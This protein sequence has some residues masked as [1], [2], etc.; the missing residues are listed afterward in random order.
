MLCHEIRGMLCKTGNRCH[1]CSLLFAV[2]EPTYKALLFGDIEPEPF[3]AAETFEL[4]YNDYPCVDEP[5][6]ELSN[7]SRTIFTVNYTQ[8][9]SSPEIGKSQTGPEPV[10]L[11]QN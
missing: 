3:A 9:K 11:S 8:L 6:L 10:S 2:T 4:K 5:Q 1:L 7:R